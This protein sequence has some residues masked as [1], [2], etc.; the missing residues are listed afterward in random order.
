[1][2]P[3]T[4]RVM[5]QSFRWD[6]LKI[7]QPTCYRACLLQEWTN[8]RLKKIYRYWQYRRRIQKGETEMKAEIGHS[9]SDN[10]GIHT[11]DLA[12][13]EAQHLSDGT[14]KAQLF[15]DKGTCE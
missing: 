4:N 5:L 14:D 9:F 7:R 11:I 3:M 13:P 8:I 2:A 6:T 12:L 15:Y 10:D 1:M